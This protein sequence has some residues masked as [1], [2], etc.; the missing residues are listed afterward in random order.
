MDNIKTDLRK[1]G[2]RY[3]LDRSDWGL[4]PLY[5]FC[6][7]GNEFSGSIKSWKLLAMLHELL[8]KMMLLT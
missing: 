6:E 7:H 3:G 1:I 8:K 4:G 5:G 2:R